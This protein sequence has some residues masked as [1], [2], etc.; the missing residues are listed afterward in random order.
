MLSNSRLACADPGCARLL[1][2]VY[3]RS[4]VDC[5]PWE[6][7]MR[8]NCAPMFKVKYGRL[9]RY[10]LRSEYSPD[11]FVP[12]PLPLPIIFTLATIRSCA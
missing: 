5:T 7:L 8:A 12:P 1:D 3:S 6:V 11:T 9:L 2:L 4:S 10:S